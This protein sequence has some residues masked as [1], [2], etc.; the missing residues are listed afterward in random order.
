MLGTVFMALT[1]PLSEELLGKL[2]HTDPASTPLTVH[3]TSLP[4]FKG[5]WMAKF[6]LELGQSS[7][8]L[9]PISVNPFKS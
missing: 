6:I 9:T 3:K 7:G 5:R 4:D 8:H 2:L 1:C